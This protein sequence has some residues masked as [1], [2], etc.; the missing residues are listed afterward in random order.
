MLIDCKDCGERVSSE[1]VTCPKCGYP[2]AEKLKEE[3]E[4]FHAKYLKA[5]AAKKR[6]IAFSLTFGFTFI[7]SIYLNFFS[8]TGFQQTL[9]SLGLPDAI[10]NRSAY[11][12]TISAIGALSAYTDAED[13]ELG[14]DP[15]HLFSTMVM[16]HIPFIGYWLITSI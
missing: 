2:V 14:R 4:I 3:N 12:P 5:K 9:L 10:A 6:W 15:S 16:I 7:V 1:A 13:V 11:I 8:E